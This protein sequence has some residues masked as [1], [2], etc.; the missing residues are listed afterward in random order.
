MISLYDHEA[1]A[2]LTKQQKD[3]EWD[4]E[5]SFDWAAPLKMDRP[6]LPLDENALY[7][8]GASPEERL[9]ISQMMGLVVAISICEMEECL[10]RLRNECWDQIK[11]EHPVSRE[12]NELGEQFFVEEKKHSE[13]FRKFFNL[14]AAK[15]NVDPKDLIEVL[16][17]IEGT[18]TETILRNNSKNFGRSFWWIVVS[19]EQQF[20][21]LFSLMRGQKDR[22][23]PLYYELHKKHFEEESRHAPF[24]FLMLELLNERDQSLKGILHRKYDLVFS[25]LLQASW[26]LTSLSRLKKLKQ[27]K[28][29]HPMF[30]ILAQTYESLS[31]QP[32]L[33]LLWRS[34]TSVPY[35]ST[36]INLQSHK[37]IIRLADQMGSFHLPNPDLVRSKMVKY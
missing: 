3:Q 18:R 25:Q 16:P 12:F 1:I 9:A 8:P 14:Y 33:R 26:T 36:L 22:I 34:F 24:P 32:K 10:L 30:E 28:G 13:S 35:I 2:R 23:E 21:H 4:L 27:L 6:L 11:N 19:V 31:K 37:R 5:R 29:K 7:F 20:L 15:L 17:V